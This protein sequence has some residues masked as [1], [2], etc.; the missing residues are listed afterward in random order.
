MFGPMRPINVQK[1]AT[2]EPCWT[3]GGAAKIDNHGRVLCDG[4]YNRAF[5]HNPSPLPPTV[6]VP[7]DA[8]M[9]QHCWRCVQTKVDPTDPWSLCGP[10]SEEL[11]HG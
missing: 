8:Y 1:E 4:C 9:M 2:S 3:C 6:P 7:S 5:V 10:C 11:R